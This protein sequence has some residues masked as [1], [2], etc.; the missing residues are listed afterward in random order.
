MTEETKRND[1]LPI[2]L[3]KVMKSS[4]LDYSMSVIIG[5]A[6]PDVRDGLKP[7]HRRILYGMSQLGLT[8]DK[9]YRKSA[10][11]VGDVMG[12]FHP[13]GDSAIYDAVARLAQP[14]NTRYLLADGQGNFGSIDGDRP[15]AMRYTE[16]RMTRLAQEMLR[17]INK[18][19]VDFQ[20]NFDEEELEPVVLPARFPNLL[21]NGSAGIAVGMA[22]N[23]APHNLGE[24]IDACIAYMKDPDCS[25]EKLMTYLPGP[26][27]PTGAQIMG[28]S[29]IKKAYET[30]KG[31]LK[32]RAVARIEESKN[33][34]RI[35]ISEI[36]YQVN[37]AKL[38]TDIAKLVREKRL[39]GISDVR[40]DTNRTGMRIIVELKRDAIPKVVL[41]NL[42]KNTQM[43]TTFGIINLALVD[44][45]PKILSLK[46]LIR[47]YVSH[48]EEVVTRRTQYDLEKAEARAH[49]IEGLKIALD[50]IDEIIRIIRSSYDSDE[51][52]KIFLEK[53]GLDD[54]QS[55][56]I[57]D[58]QLKRLSG[59]EREKLD[60]EYE[61]LLKKIARFQEILSSKR[62]LYQVIEQEMEENK[63]KYGDERRTKIMPAVDE[64]SIEDLIKEEA[65]VISMTQK[66]YIKRTPVSEYKVQRRGGKGI[67]GM[68]TQ[69]DDY[70]KHL[71]VVSSH[72]TILFFTNFGTA[73]HLNAYEIPEGS[74]TA[75]GQ[76]IINLLQ[77]EPEERVEA[78]FPVKEDDRDEN[79]YFVMVTAQGILKKTA[80]SL[81]KNIHAKG[82]RAIRLAEGD[83]LRLVR[84]GREED[85]VF[86][87]TKLGMAIHFSL[88]DIRPIRRDAMGV[89]GI[90]LDL[91]DQVIDTDIVGDNE[92][93][94]CV[95]ESGYGKKTHIDQYNLQNRGG[96]GLITYRITKKTGP[97]IA[98]C[99][100][101]E[102]DEVLLMSQNNVLIRLNVQDISTIGRST[103]GVKLKEVVNESDRV[104]AVAKYIEEL[105]EENK[106][107]Q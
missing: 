32:L 50:H 11:L 45:Q 25:T 35:V 82:I 58:M 101:R 69:E 72:D 30:G 19:T 102:D 21:V 97:L 55:Q 99:L 86:M 3:E 4:Y 51:I 74:R 54:L 106:E 44:G 87:V 61:E 40:D 65:I 33:R 36:P 79:S 24:T 105:D 63:E 28:K 20:P 70:V 64:L 93:V 16:V 89:K 1:I 12:R 43:E 94:L 39:E 81:F 41:N 8:A 76:N 13:H 47:Y 34:Y 91:K 56:A 83:E 71:F 62:V 84:I 48:Q 31:K 53:F 57:L 92:Y 49:I 29:E 107:N 80:V 9:P 75:K 15:A 95:T 104:V 26:D 98:A 14:F 6:L 85:E 68:T 23:M 46:D 37:K 5:R 66:G 7:V 88:K 18:N 22:T 100:V 59:L 42:Y 2:D 67:R 78:M 60:E 90:R 77:L 73:Y 10:R 52:K 27:F 17:D 38:I 103:Q 96:K